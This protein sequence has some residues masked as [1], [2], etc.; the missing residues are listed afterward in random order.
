M[1]MGIR[2]RMQAAINMGGTHVHLGT[3]VLEADAALA[4]DRA[5]LIVR[6]QRTGTRCVE[7]A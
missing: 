2:F 1:I 6:G 5:A 7:A 4:F 3:Y